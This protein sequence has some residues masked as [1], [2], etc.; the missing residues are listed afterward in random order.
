M[1]SEI[2]MV[3]VQGFTPRQCVIADALWAAESSDAILAL[4]LVFGK[5]EVDLVKEMI[6]AAALD[7]M[8]DDTTDA[9]NELKRFML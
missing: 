4:M 5:D 9:M 7:Q 6:T 1:R 3:T 2:P 8:A